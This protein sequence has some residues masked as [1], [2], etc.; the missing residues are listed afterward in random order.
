MC[1]F[2]SHTCKSKWQFNV[3]PPYQN[4]QGQY[5]AANKTGI[6]SNGEIDSLQKHESKQNKSFRISEPISL[7]TTFVEN[8]VKVSRFNLEW[9][10]IGK[11]CF[12]CTRV[13]KRYRPES[14]LMT[15]TNDNHSPGLGPGRLVASPHQ[16]SELSNTIACVFSRGETTNWNSLTKQA[17][18]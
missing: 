10:L 18:L 1:T 2:C 16:R 5:K 13:D 8:A 17:S 12:C 4:M 15:C 14:E 3:W 7:M 6:A 11:V 9:Y